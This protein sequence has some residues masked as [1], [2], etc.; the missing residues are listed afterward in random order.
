M[1]EAPGFDGIDDWMNTEPIGLSSLEGQ[2]ILVGFWTASCPHCAHDL[3]ALTAL[4][5]AYHEE[6]LAVVGVHSPEF[7][8]EEDKEVVD[9]AVERRGIAFPVALDPDNAT[10]RRYGNMRRP[11]KALV[12]PKGR[13]RHESV[14]AGGHTALEEQV[15]RLIR[16]GGGDPGEP[17]LEEDASPTGTVSPD[18]YA[19]AEKGRDLGNGQVYAPHTT[20]AFTDDGDHELNRIYLEGE[21]RREPEYLQPEGDGYA[22]VRFSGGRCAIVL[23][24]EGR[25]TVEVDGGIVPEK[26]RG[27]DVVEEDGATCVTVEQPGMHRVIEREEPRI[28]ELT[29][30]PD[31]GDVR[32]HKFAFR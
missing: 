23:S 2:P 24:G 27:E 16:Q 20:V 9:A 10:W 25:C 7:T 18:V 8:F 15:R 11:R 4:W 31:S 5:E 30:R 32:L 1:D 21:W 14:G 17:V 3:S 22:S 19:G 28:S 26:H 12:G 6:G 29:L 13:I